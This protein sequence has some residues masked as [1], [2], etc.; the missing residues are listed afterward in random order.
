MNTQLDEG[1]DRIVAKFADWVKRTRGEFIAI[2][3]PQDVRRLEEHLRSGGREIVLALM[4]EILQAGVARNQQR[5]RACPGCGGKRRHR[6]VRRRRL[7]GSLGSMELTGIYWQ[8]P[9]CG[10]SIHAV[11][12][13][14]KQRL[15]QL[16]EEM[17]LLL[18]VSCTSFAK[19]Q[20]LVEKLLGIEADDDTIR[21]TC[22]AEGQRTLSTAASPTPA[23]DGELLWGSCDGTMVNT[24]ET[25]WREVKAARF[26]HRKGEAAIAM[27]DCADYFLPQMAQLANA[28]LPEHPG[29][30]AI[31][32]DCAQW[33]TQG[34]S[35]HLPGWTH[36]ADYWH[37]CQH[38]HQTG[39]RLYGEHHPQARYWAQE[40]S[41]RLREL[42]ASRL[43][44]ELRPRAMDYSDLK[45]QRA[46]LDLAKFL[47]NHASRME[48]PQYIREGLP[49]DSGAMESLCKQ[50]GLRMKGPGMR[51][52]VKNVSAMACLVAR[53]AVDPK[54]AIERGLAA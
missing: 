31:T 53:W 16:L 11:D 32:S 6:G 17:V 26:S 18:G 30:L 19:A 39:E 12:L 7:A 40:L 14:C 34:V 5:L 21:R 47:D 29:P 24:R 50:L 41:R 22:E 1:T 20:L 35:K 3:D 4:Q 37:A 25:Q 38:I 44:D 52:S 36:I 33:I 51:W 23:P 10:N 54:G 13:V 8:C 48:Y 28:L 49:V 46:V 15:T 2:A 9:D 45:H 42:G 43:A 27:L